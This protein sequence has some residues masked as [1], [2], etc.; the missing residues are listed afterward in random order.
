MKKKYY[1]NIGSREISQTK[2]NNND[3][4]VIYATEDEVRLLRQRLEGMFES[5]VNAF[6]RAHVPIMPYHNDK[7]N[8]DY[9]TGITDAFQMIHE[10]GDKETKAHIENIG[11]LGD[12]HM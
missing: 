11:I 9:D 3:E 5:D 6:W 1:V 7:P 4:F 10:L 2:Y 8:D 12:N